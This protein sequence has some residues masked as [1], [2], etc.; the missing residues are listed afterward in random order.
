M[1]GTRGEGRGWVA[2]GHLRAPDGAAAA[3]HPASER[4]RWQPDRR[5]GRR[6]FVAVPLADEPRRAVEL[7]VERVRAGEPV[8][9]A[10]GR[11]DVRWVRLDGLHVTLR[12]L[13]PTPEEQLSAVGAAVAAAAA[14]AAPFEIRIHGGGAFP[15]ASRPRA[16]WLGVTAGE[17]ELAAL[18]ANL[19]A[20][21]EPLGWPPDERPFRAHLTLARSDGVA[22]ARDVVARLEELAA[23]L[24]VAWRAERLVLFESHTGR[25][26][27]VYEAL[28][29]ERFGR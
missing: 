8:P 3:G 5:P 27:A 18:A 28:R 15:G 17:P 22:R 23:E 20:A 14:T 21:L 12:F 19:D 6:L 16:V 25:G 26:A 13:G 7:L 4:R 24:D 10:R 9:P 29:E 2:A 1:N 11:P